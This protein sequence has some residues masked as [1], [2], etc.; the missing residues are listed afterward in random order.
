[1]P[2]PSPRLS[3]CKLEM[4][5][6]YSFLGFQWYAR[7]WLTKPFDL[8]PQNLIH[9]LILE[10]DPT[11][12]TSQVDFTRPHFLTK[13]RCSLK[14]LKILKMT[15]KFKKRNI[16]LY[17]LLVFILKKWIFGNNFE[18]RG[19]LDVFGQEVV[20]EDDILEILCD[21]IPHLFWTMGLKHIFIKIII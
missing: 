10:S 13:N 21:M 11:H 1:M 12:M 6:F 8:K 18:N 4:W 20:F 2:L 3:K 15:K 17:F 14:K 16:F 19:V 5:T 9:H 7:K